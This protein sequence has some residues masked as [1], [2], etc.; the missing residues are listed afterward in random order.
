MF[1]CT[2][3]NNGSRGKAFV[4]FDKASPFDDLL[5]HPGEDWKKKAAALADI[6]AAKSDK[7]DGVSG[8]AFDMVGV[9]TPPVGAQVKMIL[10]ILPDMKLR[11]LKLYT[12]EIGRGRTRPS[13][14]VDA[15]FSSCPGSPS[16]QPILDGGDH[17]RG[18]IAQVAGRDAADERVPSPVRT[19][20]ENRL[21]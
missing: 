7:T 13:R 18:A 9:C 4:P 20:Q 11:P 14:V 6:G 17:R 10:S 5:P 2:A 12:F 21:T 16:E 15:Q 19:G 3:A 8:S 1:A